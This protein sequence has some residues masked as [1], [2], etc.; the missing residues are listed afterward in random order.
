[1]ATQHETLSSGTQA[2]ANFGNGL[3]TPVTILGKTG[4]H[5][6]VMSSLNRTWHSNSLITK[7][8][9]KTILN[10]QGHKIQ[11]DI[12]SNDGGWSKVFVCLNDG[13]IA[14]YLISP[15]TK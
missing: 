12:L 7:Q 10:Y 9:D 4:V 11:V 13:W 6:K 2:I 5:Y 8:G 14:E 1:M 3:T 15:I